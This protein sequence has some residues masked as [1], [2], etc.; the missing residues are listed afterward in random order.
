[1]K[2]LLALLLCICML[3]ALAAPAFAADTRPVGTRVVIP[4]KI[5]KLIELSSFR[6]GSLLQEEDTDYF[7]TGY[8]SPLTIVA[9]YYQPATR[10]K[11]IS[12]RA[13]NQGKYVQRT[14]KYGQP[15]YTIPV[16]Q[17]D[18]DGNVIY[19]EYGVPVTEPLKDNNGDIIYTT[20]KMNQNWQVDAK[21]EN[22]NQLYGVV[23][24]DSV[25]TTGKVTTV[26]LVKDP[27]NP[28]YG[29]LT[30]DA[31]NSPAFDKTTGSVKTDAAGNPLY[32]IRDVNGNIV[33][34]AKGNTVYTASQYNVPVKENVVDDQNKAVYQ[35]TD[36]YG[37]IVVADADGNPQVT[38]TQENTPVMGFT[39][40]LGG[41][42]Y[43]YV[44][45]NYTTGDIVWCRAT[46]NLMGKLIHYMLTYRTE[47]NEEYTI[48]YSP[49]DK[50]QK[51]WY[52][53]VTPWGE[54]R[55]AYANS[56]KTW[57]D[58]KTG[59][60]TN[61]SSLNWDLYPLGGGYFNNPPRSKR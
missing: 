23:D 45:E 34:D 52:W 12:S 43:Y 40:K 18:A 60:L 53:A 50:P 32:T 41:N 11:V 38:S 35:I 21:D 55:Y 44:E 22:G 1:M 49:E 5:D 15:L 39:G 14:N 30:T 29:V 9:Y 10:S 8:K 25:T 56:M 24:T 4:A 58:E 6:K 20:Q 19:N 57:R 61:S 17:R 51:G 36:A 47:N 26:Q 28:N 2:K 54:E 33:T 59:L 16:A 7:K 48:Q 37:N 13:L 3:A 42:W 46:Y 27:A 31:A